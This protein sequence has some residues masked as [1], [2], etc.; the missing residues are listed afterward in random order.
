MANFS[1]AN[2][3]PQPFDNFN[4]PLVHKVCEFYKKI[5]LLSYKISKRDRLGM[6][7]KVEN[8]ILEILALSITASLESKNNKFTFLNSARIKIE[9]LKIFFRIV[10]ELNIINQQKYIEIELDLQELSKMTNGWIKYLK[11]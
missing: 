10:H 7:A 5:Y 11:Q 8:I 3:P 4:V 9:S 2:T 1:S 6:F